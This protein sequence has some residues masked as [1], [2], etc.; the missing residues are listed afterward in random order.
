MTT[1]PGV[2][3]IFLLYW[4]GCFDILILVSQKVPSS[5]R[6]YFEV[7]EKAQNPPI[8]LHL[9]HLNNLCGR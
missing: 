4:S 8:H 3:S 1:T 9:F 5:F 6:N 7:D 2:L